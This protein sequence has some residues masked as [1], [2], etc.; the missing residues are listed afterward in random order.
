MDFSLTEEQQAIRETFRSFV[1]DKVV[2][3][4]GEIDRAA[5]FPRDEFRAVRL[6]DVG[7]R[8]PGVAINC[9]PT[10][11]FYAAMHCRIADPLH[12][13]ENAGQVHVPTAR[14]ADSAAPAFVGI[15]SSR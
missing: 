9:G 7:V 6:L 2:P 12:A 14:K 1:D 10:R 13:P 8:P 4:A 3:R 15:A 5:V 11:P